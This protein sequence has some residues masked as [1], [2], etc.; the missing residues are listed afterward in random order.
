MSAP[1]LL[2]VRRVAQPTIDHFT[3]EPPMPPHLVAGDGAFLR[4]L[5][6]RPLRELQVDR[7]LVDRED[8]VGGDGS[9]ARLGGPSLRGGWLTA[10]RGHVGM[11]VALAV[12]VKWC[13]PCRHENHSA[14]DERAAVQPDA[15]DGVVD[16]L[17][18]LRFDRHLLAFFLS[19]SLLDKSASLLARLRHGSPGGGGG[20]MPTLPP[21]PARPQA[22]PA[23]GADNQVAVRWD[24]VIVCVV[25]AFNPR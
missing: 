10:G 22:P 7:Q 25:L 17:E 18:E 11:S 6:E 9:P 20:L 21:P 1:H 8:R 16:A 13:D 15:I 24:G 3:V 4:Q 23:F 2:P 12:A 14:R 5:V 19:V